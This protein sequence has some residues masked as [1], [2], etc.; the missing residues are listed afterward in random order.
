[1]DE[2]SKKYSDDMFYDIVANTEEKVDENTDY[3]DSMLYE[4]LPNEQEVYEDT[5]YDD[6]MLSD[7]KPDIQIAE[8]EDAQK[9]SDIKFAIPEN[10]DL[11]ETGEISDVQYE[12]MVEDV[13]YNDRMIENKARFEHKK[14][15]I[16]A[17]C[18]SNILV[19]LGMILFEA[20]G[21]WK[22]DGFD[23]SLLL[24]GIVFVAVSVIGIITMAKLKA[25]WFLVQIFVYALS[26]LISISIIPLVL[27]GMNVAFFLIAKEIAE[28]K[29]LEGY[30]N[31]LQKKIRNK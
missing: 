30:P 17:M 20:Y 6:S 2:N 19:A 12:E 18:G 15:E 26:A 10:T 24:G 22:V 13:K 21:S 11:N 28:I 3:D 1:M 14:K 16:Y 31:F 5:D 23:F 27:V 7:M 8:T 9:Y 25:E 29:Q 4:M